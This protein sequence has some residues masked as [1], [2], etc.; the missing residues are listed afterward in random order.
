[1]SLWTG[2]SCTILTGCSVELFV[3]KI[4][5]DGSYFSNVSALKPRVKFGERLAFAGTILTCIFS[6]DF[7]I[8]ASWI[9]MGV[10]RVMRVVLATPG[11]DVKCRFIST[12]M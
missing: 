11:E 3:Q 6:T 2:V 9:Q 7:R 5:Q 1:V 12:T 4:R 10:P 8:P